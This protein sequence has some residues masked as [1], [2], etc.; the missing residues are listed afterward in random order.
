MVAGSLDAGGTPEALLELPLRRCFGGAT[1]TT[2]WMAR[3]YTPGIPL[4]A[5]NGNMGA[6]AL[7][8]IW[9]ELQDKDRE[10]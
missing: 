5:E 9:R 8:L 4:L 6:R 10:C 3:G 1:C 2:P 7:C